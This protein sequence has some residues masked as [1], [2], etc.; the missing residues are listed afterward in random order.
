MT[1]SRSI[2]VSEKQMQEI[3]E[4]LFSKYPYLYR[5]NTAYKVK[6]IVRYKL[7]YPARFEADI[8]EIIK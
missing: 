4:H 5:K 8:T 7:Y 1:R 2:I 6:M 3:K